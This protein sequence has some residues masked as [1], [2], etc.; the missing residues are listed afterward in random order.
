MI[1]AGGMEEGWRL[2][3][4]VHVDAVVFLVLD[5]EELEFINEL[6]VPAQMPIGG[7]AE[8]WGLSVGEVSFH[9]D[10]GG[11]TSLFLVVPYLA[12][13]GPVEIRLAAQQGIDAWVT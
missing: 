4:A 10:E 2:F 13:E 8:S 1:E 12:H 7:G 9:V 5:I 6:P 11:V 3:C